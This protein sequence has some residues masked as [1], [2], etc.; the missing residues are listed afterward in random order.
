M[1]KDG[2]DGSC[3]ALGRENKC[4]PEEERALRITTHRSEDNIK[5]DHQV[6]V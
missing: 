3:R 2:I 5:M 6:I 1:K 4:K